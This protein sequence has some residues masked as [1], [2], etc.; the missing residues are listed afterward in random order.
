MVFLSTSLAG[1]RY[2]VFQWPKL[3][4]NIQKLTGSGFRS[5]DSSKRVP[6]EIY[7]PFLAAARGGIAIGAALRAEAFAVLPAERP[8]GQSQKYLLTHGV[9]QQ[10]AALFIITDFRLVF[11][12][13]VLAGLIIHAAGPEDEVEVPAEELFDGF[14]APGA[15]QFKRAGKV[16]AQT[17]I[18]DKVLGAAMFDDQFGLALELQGT[19]LADILGIVDRPRCEAFVQLERLFDELYGS[20]EH[21]LRVGLAEGGVNEPEYGVVHPQVLRKPNG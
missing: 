2:C 13:C 12:N 16:R 21:G 17:D 3:V 8:T 20:D 18:V 6:A 15:E 5:G 1:K 10:Q 11:R 19:N 9:L 4:Q 7:R 14:D